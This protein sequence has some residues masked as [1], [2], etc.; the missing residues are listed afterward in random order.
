M[1]L[2]M[3]EKR[4]KAFLKKE[5]LFYFEQVQNVIVFALAGLAC[6]LAG[7]ISCFAAIPDNALDNMLPGVYVYEENGSYERTGSVETSYV[8]AGE[9]WEAL[10]SYAC[11]DDKKLTNGPIRDGELVYSEQEIVD[12]A[13]ALFDNFDGRVPAL[14]GT[15]GVTLDNGEYLM[16]VYKGTFAQEITLKEAVRNK[17]GSVDAEYVYSMQGRG[18]EMVPFSTIAVHFEPN[19]HV[20][21]S[22][23]TP[24]YYKFAR[25]RWNL[26][27][28]TETS[29]TTAVGDYVLPESNIRYYTEDELRGLSKQQLA[30]ARNEIYAR[31]GR[32]FKDQSLQ[33]YFDSK[34]WYHG[35]I[36]PDA[37]DAEVFNQYENANLKLIVSIEKG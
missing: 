27:N 23:G 18:S 5:F 32:R 9:F 19:S 34:S 28:G 6:T 10:H 29:A 30:Y 33:S 3:Q 12:I 20:N 2:I 15:S 21:I 17:D 4:D 7:S 37:F 26:A 25:V 24:L 8:D 16:F 13:Y 36:E 22:S 1:S 11:W 14:E 35:T 31:H